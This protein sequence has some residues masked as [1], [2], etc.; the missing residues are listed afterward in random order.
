MFLDG[1]GDTDGF[2]DDY[3]FLISGLLELY[4]VTFH[5]EY[6]QWANTLQQTQ[7]KLLWDDE[8]KGFFRTSESADV[9]L[10]LKDDADSAE[11]SANSISTRNFLRL[12]SLL[13]DRTYD[14][15]AVETCQAFS[16]ELE[17]SPWAFPA[18]L[19]SVV[20]C[21]D[22]M[23][24]IVVIGKETDEM[25][26]TFLQTIWGRLLVNT[27]IIHLDPQDPDEWLLSR[28]EV[29]RD[30]LK[31]SSDGR[32]FVTICEGYTCGLPIFDIEALNKSLEIRE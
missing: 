5:T 3:A 15:K 16:G 20:G 30:A 19:M 17:N 32:P 9:I 29:L 14:E 4:Q 25:T 24:E 21:L 13:G 6:L 2:S 11:P 10:R 12:G 27:V 23:R 1:P 22:G 7:L 26:R 18:M 31:I 8:A 28:N